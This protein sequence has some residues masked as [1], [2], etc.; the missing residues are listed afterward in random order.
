[1]FLYEIF[2]APPSLC[3]RYWNSVG[4]TWNRGTPLR[5]TSISWFGNRCGKRCPWWELGRN[6]PHRSLQQWA[7]ELF[8]HRKATVQWRQSTRGQNFRAGVQRP[9]T[10]Y[11]DT[12]QDFV[13]CTRFLPVPKLM[14][15]CT[16]LFWILQGWV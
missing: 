6:Q 8:F 7:S 13:Y 10:G 1:M 16:Q 4:V 2:T 9:P 3:R 5:S 12:S 11:R 14:D 15:L